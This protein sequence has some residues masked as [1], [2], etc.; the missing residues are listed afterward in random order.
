MGI[1]QGEDCYSV[2]GVGVMSIN[3]SSPTLW[4]LP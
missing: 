4:I 1:L 3:A 2:S